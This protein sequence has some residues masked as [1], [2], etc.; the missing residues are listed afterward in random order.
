MSNRKVKAIFFSI[1]LLAM[2][3]SAPTV[4]AWVIN[5]IT[6][7]FYANPSG[8]T[9]HNAILTRRC[10]TA[11]YHWLTSERLSPNPEKFGPWKYDS[12]DGCQNNYPI[13]ELTTEV[14]KICVGASDTDPGSGSV[15]YEHDNNRCYKCVRTD[16]GTGNSVD[17]VE[18]FN[19]YGRVADN[20]GNPLV[21]VAV[22]NNYGQTV[23]TDS[24]GN[25]AFTN[26]NAG[27]YTIYVSADN[28]TFS[29]SSISLSGGPPYNVREQNFVGTY[30]PPNFSVSGRVTDDGGGA[31]SG[32]T[33]SD[34]AGHTAVTDGDGHY[35]LGG[36]SSGSHTISPSKSG[37]TFVPSSR[38]VSG[39][40]DVTGQDFTVSNRYSISG[41]VTDGSNP[42]PNVPVS[43]NRLLLS[44][45]V[46]HTDSNGY[47]TCSD[48]AMGLYLLK[49]PAGSTYKL[50]P[51][52]RIVGVPSSAS[53][54]DFTTT[55][56]Y[57]SLKG[58]V[59]S[60][61][62]GR[63]IPGAHVSA[64]GQV[65][66]TDANGNYNLTNVIPGHHAIHI[67]A[68]GYQD[69]QGNVTIQANTS[70]THNAA[71]EPVRAEGYRLP[72]PGGAKYKCTQ[73]N[74]GA[75][76]HQS[77]T[78]RRYAL[79]FGMVTGSNLVATRAGKVVY[80][81]EYSSSGGCSSSYVNSYNAVAIQ[82]QDG[83]V[84]WYFH[85]QKDG[86]SV[87]LGDSVQAGQV[88]AQSGQTGWSCGAHLHYERRES[89]QSM[90][91]VQTSFLD[92]STNGGIPQGGQWYTSDNYPAVMAAA[93]DVQADTVPPQGQVQ[94]R[95]TGQ[96]SW[97]AQLYAFDYDSD[98]VSM[99]LAASQ[100]DLE[101]AVWQPLQES[102][103]WDDLIVWA[104][105]KDGSD[106]VS[107]VYS[108][109]VDAI[110]YEPIQPAFAVSPTLCVGADPFIHNQTW[111]FCEQC[112]WKWDLGDGNYSLE[113]I[114]ALPY[115]YMGYTATGLY[116]ITL[117]VTNV[118]SVQ[119]VSHQ[120]QVVPSPSAGF[121]LSRSGAAVTVQAE[122]VNATNWLWDFGDGRV[123][124]GVAAAT[125]TYTDVASLNAYPYP[126]QLTVIGQNGCASSSY[127]FT[128][129]E[130]KVYLPLIMR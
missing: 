50:S 102:M 18:V 123:A 36:L 65:G 109:T 29:P 15:L 57:G 5:S 125:H 34:G 49:A 95:A 10:I 116:T 71:L 108:D 92:V 127:Q 115:P 55:P 6:H 24:S 30:L 124:S 3:V 13:V 94:L 8:M 41:H 68:G 35:T 81:K 32:I 106:N 14:V 82:H 69:Y 43:C 11:N 100:A 56:Q 98:T 17:C 85:L 73:G 51:S 2:V 110:V 64:G 112:A 103:T 27:S 48:L 111:P 104:Q 39:P 117:T 89:R 54:E 25:Y 77:W 122:E 96:S 42:V 128:P 76:S 114:P 79:D 99:R 107:A 60:P 40:P 23:Y 46:V 47:Y 22:F 9:F 12:I 88:I 86:I 129:P 120:A 66:Y 37:Y 105:F 45:R 80:A 97:K 126:V 91:S 53:G 4:W 33:V 84:S 70:H 59:T 121:T 130:R 16:N 1:M 93:L 101:S 75:Y 78:V 21:G 44:E 58:R 119:S 72:Y 38:A 62:L 52:V 113:A 31:V 20:S 90:Q 26:L 118:D 74:D 28:Y 87:N 61:T 63:V 7:T 19:I 67:S 83:T